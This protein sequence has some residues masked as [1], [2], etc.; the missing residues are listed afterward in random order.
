MTL[1]EA[2]S[3]A[4]KESSERW[5]AYCEEHSE[6]VVHPVLVVQ[7]RDAKGKAISET[8]LTSLVE[9][10]Q[11]SVGPLPDRAFAHS[12]EDRST[13]E[14]G[15]VSVCY[16]APSDIETDPDV[17]IVLFKTSLT[18]GWDCPRSEVMMSFRTAKDATYIAQLVGRMV[19]TPLAR[20]SLSTRMRHLGESIREQSPV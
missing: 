5:G 11:E 16:V 15:A 8:D 19:R 6:P 17:R 10:I 2:A 1:L 14:A 4:W 18:T 20:R 3:F 9:T 12:F 13:V 7:V